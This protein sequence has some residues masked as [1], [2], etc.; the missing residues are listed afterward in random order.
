MRLLLV[1]DD[2]MVA[3]GIKLGLSG[4]GVCTVDWV[5]SA[6]R[7]E[8]E[9]TQSDIVRRGGGRHWSAAAWMVLALTQRPAQKRGTAMPVLILTARD[10]LAGPGAGAGHGGRRL[11]G[12]ALRVA[13]AA[14]PPAG[15][16]APIP[17]CH[18]RATLSFGPLELDTAQRQACIRATGWR[19]PEPLSW[20][21]A[22]GP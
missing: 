4:C 15:A 3:S 13:R 21:H 19:G 20:G 5:G 16:A 17:G 1:E 11:H 12:Q 18:H 22:N 8:L 14:G 2:V 9:V 10:A 7:A 6:E